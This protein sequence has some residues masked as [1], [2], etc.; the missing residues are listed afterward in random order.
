[1][2][3]AVVVLAVTLGFGLSGC[4]SNTPR[5]RLYSSTPN[6][7][8]WSFVL[9]DHGRA[10]QLLVD[11]RPR[12]D[13][14]RAGISI[15]CELRGLF[16]GGHIVE[17]R[18]AG[19]I[20]RRSAVLGRAWPSR[21]VLVRARDLGT[22]AGA[23]HAGADAILV[24][25]GLEAGAFEELVE[26]SHKAGLAVFVEAATNGAGPATVSAAVERYALDGV[27]G[28]TLE[29]SVTKRFPQARV[30]MVDAKTSSVLASD[31]KPYAL[32]DLAQGQGVVETHGAL[33][34]GL[35][36]AAGRGAITDGG[37]FAL[38]GVRRRHKA[39]RDGASTSLYDDGVRRAL[40]LTAGGDALTLVAN[41]SKG[42]W[43]PR[44]TL[45]RV[46]I[47]LLGGPMS[48]TGPTVP[49]GDIAAILASPDPDHTRY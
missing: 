4:G 24:P 30:L 16:P 25:E 45:P 44:L 8:T 42:A 48:P 23:A 43:T 31:D 7:A 2:M 11:G 1:M 13:C 46:P 32:G 21:P 14:Y 20:L 35:V 26:A 5:M 38:L 10:A 6:G 28:A 27:V 47:D 15:R 34:L 22:V 12:P 29:P 40:R 41:G 33:Q 49:A 3:R 18:L 36:L 37:G 39:L 17:L 19:G 9:H